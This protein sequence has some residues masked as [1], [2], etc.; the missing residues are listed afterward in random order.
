LVIGDARIMNT[1]L[2]RGRAWAPATKAAALFLLPLPLAFAVLG[3]LIAGDVS[4]LS[5]AGGALGCFWGAGALVFRALAADA[6]YFLG[7]L[8]DP[9]RVPM[10]LL[11]ALLTALGAALAALAGGHAVAGTAAFAGLAALGHFAFFGRDLKSPRIQVAVVEG[12]D[13]DTVTQQLK[14]AYGRLRGIEAAAH[15]IAVPEFRE[16]LSRI[17]A[18]GRTILGEIERDP[19]EAPRARRFLNLY[20]DGAERI[21]LDYARTHSQ[22]RNQPLEQNFRNLLVDM[23]GT[24]A[25]QYKKLVERDLLSLDVDIEV[26]NARLKR[27]GLG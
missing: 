15:G 16:R 26:L 7:E 9:P 18:I 1:L 10:K 22:L 14:Q 11:S 3:A 6:R 23:E 25:E 8:P 21:T 13:A 17:T 12:V 2:R 20:L 27:D 19:R 5:L 4:R 24:F